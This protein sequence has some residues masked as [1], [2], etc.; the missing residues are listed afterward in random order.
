MEYSSLQFTVK[1]LDRTYQF[2]RN[3]LG[4]YIERVLE[5]ESFDYLLLKKDGY[6]L[7]FESEEAVRKLHPKLSDKWGDGVRGC[8]VALNFVVCNLYEIYGR[9][10]AHNITILYDI[11]EKHY[12]MREVWL[13][14]PDNYLIVLSEQVK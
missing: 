12:G 11:A 7:I 6:E 13:F 1:D 8:G 5:E 9:L 14:D 10:R 3:V 4:F 2:Y